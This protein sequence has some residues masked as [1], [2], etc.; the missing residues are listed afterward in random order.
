MKVCWHKKIQQTDSA[1]NKTTFRIETVPL[2]I[3]LHYWL[4]MRFIQHHKTIKQRMI[5][6]KIIEEDKK[7]LR[8]KAGILNHAR[9]RPL[10]HTFG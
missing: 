7:L 3:S 2:Q 9:R 8:P 4:D 1:K 5:N 6:M 10:F